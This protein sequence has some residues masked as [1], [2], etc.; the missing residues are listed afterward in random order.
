MADIIEEEKKLVKKLVKAKLI[1][2]VPKQKLANLLK[3]KVDTKE[4]VD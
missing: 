3:D 1:Y 4:L 2:I